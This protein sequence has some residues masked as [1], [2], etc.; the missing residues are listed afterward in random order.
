MAT[1]LDLSM[2]SFFKPAFIFLFVL[3][4]FYAILQKTQ[5]FGENKGMNLLVSF[6]VSFLFI[7]TPGVSDVISLAMPWFVILVVVILVIAL[8]FMMMGV[9]EETIVT[10]VF[11]EGWFIWTIVLVIIL[12]IFGYAFSVVY[13]PAVQSVT[14]ESS[15]QGVMSDIGKV[16]FH[17]KLLGVLFLLL[18]ASQ[19][20]RL[21]SSNGEVKT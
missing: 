9:K 21:I 1:V 2:L 16:L 11:H 19:T 8:V 3:G 18:V 12:G 17:P 4:I 14:G 6:V 20:V 15:D 5:L 7:I 10:N 13:G